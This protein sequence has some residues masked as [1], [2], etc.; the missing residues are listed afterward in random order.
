MSFRPKPTPSRDRSDCS[1]RLNLALRA[2]TERINLRALARVDETGMMKRFGYVTQDEY[3]QLEHDNAA[4]I[5]EL[6]RMTQ[7]N[8]DENIKQRR[9]LVEQERVYEKTQGELIHMT[10]ANQAD[11][12]RLKLQ[13]RECKKENETLKIEVKHFLETIGDMNVQLNT[14]KSTVDEMRK[15]IDD[16]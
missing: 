4:H 3:D 10:Q 1:N 12:A 14:C 13:L 5:Q 9:S 2:G 16:L 7:Q 15:R 11:I 6:T 8:R